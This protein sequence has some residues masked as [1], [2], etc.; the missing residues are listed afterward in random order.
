MR[1]LC[2]CGPGGAAGTGSIFVSKSIGLTYN[3]LVLLA[4]DIVG[5]FAK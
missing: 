5:A 1:T 4:G 3:P 2:G